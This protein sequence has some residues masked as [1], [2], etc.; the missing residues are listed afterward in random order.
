MNAKEQLE[1]MVIEDTKTGQQEVIPVRNGPLMFLIVIVLIISKDHFVE[2]QITIH[3]F[4][5]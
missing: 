2:I 5:V 1:E 4:G 3:I